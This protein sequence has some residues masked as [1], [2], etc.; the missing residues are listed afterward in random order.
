MI[1][2]F[3]IY[4]KRCC[5]IVLVL[6]LCAL[7]IAQ[8]KIDLTPIQY[9]TTINS[10]EKIIKIE[11]GHYLIDF[12][13]AYFGTVLIKSKQDQKDSLILHIGEKLSNTGKVDKN[14]NGTIRY[15]KIKLNQLKANFDQTI[16]LFPYKRNSNPPAILLP[17]S[18]GVV[19][20]FRYCEIENLQIPIQDIEVYQKAFH[21][22]FNDEA[23]YFT[24]SDTLLNQVWD[25]CRHTIKATTFT[26]Y[27]IDGDRERIPYEADAYI[28]Q[29][30]HYS[31]DSVYLMARRTNEYFIDHATWPTEWL[32]HTV[33]LF[34]QDFMYTG[35]IK[36][37]QKHYEILKIK[38][39][40]DLARDD[41]LISVKSKK[42]TPEL[43]KQLGYNNSKTIIKD[44]V[45]WPPARGNS[46]KK[47][48]PEMGERDGYDM[49]DVNT[50]VNSF[51]YYNMV[52]MSEIASALGKT[53]DVALFTN[54]AE[55]VK[56]TIN[57]KLLNEKRGIYM[58]GEDSEHASLHANMFPLAFGL[59]PEDHVN[60]VVDFI[61]SRGMVCSVYGSQYLLEGLFKAN[62]AQY[63]LDLITDTSHDRTWW[64]MI[65]SGS[66]MT[67]EAWDIKYK[68]N[69]DWNHAWGT[70][71]L[72]IITRY[73]WGIQPT[74]PGYKIVLVK[75]QMGDLTYSKIKVPTLNGCI[76]GNYEVKNNKV[77]FE[78]ELPDGMNG[79]FVVPENCKELKGRRKLNVLNR[80][81][82]LKEGKNHITFIKL[83]Q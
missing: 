23:G 82:K 1:N 59:V 36:P 48:L 6:Y 7:S 56:E 18:I 83:G 71:P 12:G 35:D 55:K 29:L 40:K 13:K 74:V 44:I 26:G 31:V 8:N 61:K 42:L 73:M 51:F 52:L 10:Y 58:D 5:F 32:L 80:N 27:Y 16:N 76:Y 19:M 70:A 41:G 24:S 28:N 78:I 79:Q 34:Y 46:G 25:I 75:P 63:A 60:T 21:Y 54:N 72:N 3:P 65:K 49:V 67:W 20:P 68:S 33:M 4:K 38:T 64:N 57:T 47:W 22:K 77:I 66:T 11:E 81:F 14:P 15:Q 53:E 30:S 69:L 62:E 17:D 37:L 39:L 9:R 50:V 43:K 45:D 2:T